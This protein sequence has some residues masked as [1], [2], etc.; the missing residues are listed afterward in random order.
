MDDFTRE[1]SRLFTTPLSHAT[2]IEMSKRLQLEFKPKLRVGTANMLPSFTHSMPTGFERGT[3]LSLDVGGSTLR[4]AIVE[5]TGR[6]TNSKNKSPMEITALQSWKINDEVK[7]M[8]GREFFDWM[9]ERIEDTLSGQSEGKKT[10]GHPLSMGL[11]WSFPIEQTSTRTGTLLSMGK[12]FQAHTGL[13]G[14]DLSSLIETSCS[15]R[16]LSVRAHL[17]ID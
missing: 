2:L 1:V 11:S 17:C 10:S 8:K 4:V 3:F 15:S 12:G 14:S 16:K 13:L 7:K 9:A 6:Y 5:L